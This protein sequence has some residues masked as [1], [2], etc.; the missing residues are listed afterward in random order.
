MMFCP[1]QPAAS[2]CSAR[3]RKTIEEYKKKKQNPD[4]AQLLEEVRIVAIARIDEAD[5]A[6]SQFERTMVENGVP[7]DSPSTMSLRTPRF[8]GPSSRFD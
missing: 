8:G 5:L 6:L 4:L 7:M 2:N 1:P 3:F